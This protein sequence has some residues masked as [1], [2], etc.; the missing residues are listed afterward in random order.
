MTAVLPTPVETG[1]A[2]IPTATVAARPVLDV[3]FENALAPR[4]LLSLGTLKLAET[5]TPVTPEQAPQLL[6][7]WQALDNLSQSGTSAQAEVDALLTQIEVV[8]TPEQIMAINAMRLTQ[9]ELQAWAQQN[10]VATASGGGGQG[11][12]QGQGSGSG[13]SPEARATKQAAQGVAAS[14][15]DNGLSAAVTQALLVYLQSIQ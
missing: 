5:T 10:G 9:V 12:G 7:L 13:M 11:Q 14:G 1:A 3:S 6:M 15:G 2:A 8:Y 4:L